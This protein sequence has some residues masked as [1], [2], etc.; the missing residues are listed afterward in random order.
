MM[1]EPPRSSPTRIAVTG[2]R[3]GVV[4]IDAGLLPSP[5]RA[6][7]GSAGLW[8]SPHSQ[9]S[10]RS[11]EAVFGCAGSLAR[12]REPRRRRRRGSRA[13]PARCGARGAGP[14]RSAARRRGRPRT[15]RTRAG[16][17][18]PSSSP[19]RTS[20]GPPIRRAPARTRACSRERLRREPGGA[21][22][23]VERV[24][25][26]PPPD[27]RIAR[28][29]LRRDAVRHRQRRQDP[30]RAAARVASSSRRASS[31]G[32]VPSGR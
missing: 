15:P 8:P 30:A 7:S 16:G 12:W 2:L 6:G 18:R 20:V 9:R 10:R 4:V 5:V 22:R 23:A 27:L 14:G 26:Q 31:R 17:T 1:S 11:P 24:R 13:P 25:R 19:W 32:R 21:G 29:R 28:Q 3:D